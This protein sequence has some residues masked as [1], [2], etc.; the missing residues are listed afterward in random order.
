[1]VATYLPGKRRSRLRYCQIYKS[2]PLSRFKQKRANENGHAVVLIGAGMKG[3]C[4]F[5]YFLNSWGKKFCARRNVSGEIVTGGIGKIRATDLTK[6]VI[7]LSHPDE[8]GNSQNYNYMY[9]YVISVQS[10]DLS[11]TFIKFLY[12]Y[13]VFTCAC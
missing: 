12:I 10:M 6:N 1:M 7:R 11:S 4:Q 9:C 5:F 3:G 13:C 2:P 8:E